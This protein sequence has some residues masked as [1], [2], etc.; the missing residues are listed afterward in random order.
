MSNGNAAQEMGITPLLL[1]LLSCRTPHLSSTD[2]LSTPKSCAMW[3]CGP[4]PGLS[5]ETSD[6]Q[7]PKLSTLWVGPQKCC[8]LISENRN[9]LV[10]NCTL[11]LEPQFLSVAHHQITATCPRS[12]VT[13]LQT[14]LSTLADSLISVFL[15]GQELHA[16]IHTADFR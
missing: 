16:L 11:S 7:P 8:S 10:G 4:L 15:K 6:L 3:A 12:L 2:I 14:H 9:T 1:D 13:I 5:R